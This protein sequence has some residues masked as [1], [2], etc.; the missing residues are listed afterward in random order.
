MTAN[1]KPSVADDS[2][3]AS[4]RIKLLPFTKHFS[5]EERD[6]NLKSLFRTEE[7]KSGILNWLIEG[8]ALYKAEGLK[9]TQELEALTE[10]YR[11]END[12]VGQY[13]EDRVSFNTTEKTTVKALRA[14]YEVWCK[15]IGAK[16]LGY[17]LFK[18]ELEK[19]E[20]E[21]YVYNKQYVVNGSIHD[22]Y[23]YAKEAI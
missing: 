22:S 10:E 5:K 16:P 9:N 23:N 2:L 17:R 18:E 20:I 1:S 19:H 4:D 12:L 7:S 13:L 21:V 3:F 8:Y 6:T 15:V 14:A 11:K